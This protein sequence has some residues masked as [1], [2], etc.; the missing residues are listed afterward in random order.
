MIVLLNFTFFFPKYLRIQY[1]ITLLHHVAYYKNILFFFNAFDQQLFLF[2]KIYLKPFFFLIK[3][4]HCSSR[5]CNIFHRTSAL[6]LLK[7]H[8]FKFKVFIKTRQDFKNE[9]KNKLKHTKAITFC[10]SANATILSNPLSW[11][12]IRCPYT[13]YEGKIYT[14]FT[15]PALPQGQS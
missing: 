13:L 9:M 4:T 3:H 12:H 1:I 2:F 14:A 7:I 6:S 5:Y 8:N 11:F 10:K 15:F